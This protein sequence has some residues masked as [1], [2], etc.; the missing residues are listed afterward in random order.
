MT[1]LSWGEYE[2]IDEG[3]GTTVFTA[4]IPLEIEE[5]SALLGRIDDDYERAGWD[6]A[7]EGD[8]VPSSAALDNRGLVPSD[9]EGHPRSRSATRHPVP[10]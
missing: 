8:Y 10:S 5:A 2:E 9:A 1:R 3:A 7:G 4:D 6:V